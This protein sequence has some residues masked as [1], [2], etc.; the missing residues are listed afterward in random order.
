[1]KLIF[2]IQISM[3]V[4]YKLIVFDGDGQAFPELP[5]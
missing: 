1:M 4:T 5:K 2:Y 3:S